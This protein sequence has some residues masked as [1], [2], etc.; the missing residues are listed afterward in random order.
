MNTIASLNR[1]HYSSP[2]KKN[3]VQ[4][5]KEQGVAEP[6]FEP[7][8]SGTAF[9][10]LSTRFQVMIVSNGLVLLAVRPAKS[11]EASRCNREGLFVFAS[12]DGRW[13]T[14]FLKAHLPRTVT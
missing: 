7:R 6:D 10:A 1:G 8:A 13:R 12:K 2:N 4:K 3:E 11:P 9:N 5:G 14:S